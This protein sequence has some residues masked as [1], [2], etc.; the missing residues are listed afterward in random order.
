MRFSSVLNVKGFVPCE[1]LLSLSL[2]NMLLY[3]E[4]NEFFL[5]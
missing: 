1:S 3:T 4:V 2:S 5:K